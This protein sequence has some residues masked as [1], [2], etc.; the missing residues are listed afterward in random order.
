MVYGSIPYTTILGIY[1]AGIYSIPYL[2]AR[3]HERSTQTG[4]IFIV[5]YEY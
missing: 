2:V 5:I 4:S 3:Y 1:M